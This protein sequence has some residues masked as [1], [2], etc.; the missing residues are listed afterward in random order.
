MGLTEGVYTLR[1]IQGFSPDGPLY[2]TS[3][4]VDEA[5]TTEIKSPN[6]QEWGLVKKGDKWLILG[7]PEVTNAPGIDPVIF[8]FKNAEVSADP[9]ITLS[10]PMQYT[11]TP[12]GD[13]IYTILP[14]NI[15]TEVGV[16]YF[17]GVVGN[18][19]KIKPIVVNPQ[20]ADATPLWLLKKVRD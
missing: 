5:I 19:L 10:A 1:H 4:A 17:V 20:E 3:H 15:P 6:G 12:W 7:S 14:T 13:D 2:A 18:I 8:G 11:I 16:D 9:A